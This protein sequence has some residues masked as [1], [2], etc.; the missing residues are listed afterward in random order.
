MRGALRR[1]EESIGWGLIGFRL[2]GS[3]YWGS[4]QC[5]VDRTSPQSTTCWHQTAAAPCV[6]SPANLR[7][8]MSF[9]ETACCKKVVGVQAAKTGRQTVLNIAVA[10]SPS[11]FSQNSIHHQ[12]HHSFQT[13]C[14]PL[15]TSFLSSLIFFQMDGNMIRTATIWPPWPPSY[16]FLSYQHSFA[17]ES[18]QFNLNTIWWSS[19]PFL[20]ISRAQLI[21]GAPR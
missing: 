11:C 9:A 3:S 14:L 17:Q 18:V 15:L 5:L 7:A 6:G 20:L 2:A 8:S 1:S 19:P 16:S 13:I 4:R 21:S 12:I 10:T